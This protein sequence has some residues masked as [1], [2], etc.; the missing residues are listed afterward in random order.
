[1]STL[2]YDDLGSPDFVKRATHHQEAQY[3]ADLARISRPM[4][5]WARKRL[6]EGFTVAAVN[7]CLKVANHR[8]AAHRLVP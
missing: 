2:S 1:M 6:D 5:R 8:A 7:D 4:S 3:I